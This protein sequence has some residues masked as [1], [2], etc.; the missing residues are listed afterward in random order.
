MNM[1]AKTTTPT[2]NH[3]PNKPETLNFR[4]ILFCIIFVITQSQKAQYT[5]SKQISW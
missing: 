5:N 4:N 1:D 2:E 3:Q